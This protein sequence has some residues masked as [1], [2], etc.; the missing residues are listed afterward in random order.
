MTT[1]KWFITYATLVKSYSGSQ[2]V[3]EAQRDLAESVAFAGKTGLMP[4]I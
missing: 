3:L 2:K 4:N 1:Q